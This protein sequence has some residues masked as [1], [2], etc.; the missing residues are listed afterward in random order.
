MPDGEQWDVHVYNP[1]AK[2][3]SHLQKYFVETLRSR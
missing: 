1:T 3:D 2:L